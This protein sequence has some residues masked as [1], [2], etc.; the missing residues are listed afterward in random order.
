MTLTLYGRKKDIDELRKELGCTQDSFAHIV[1]VAART[2]ARWEKE[3]ISPHALAIERLARLFKLVLKL[4]EVFEK[5]DASEWLHTPNASLNYR[6]PLKVM[7]EGTEGIEKVQ[8]LLES[9][10]WGILS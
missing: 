1:G 3:D 4:E 7:E 10:E 6:T 2:V 5:K 9:I 8:Y